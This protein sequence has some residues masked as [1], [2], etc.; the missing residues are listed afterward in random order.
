MKYI[1]RISSIIPILV[2]NIWLLKFTAEYDG[3][4]YFLF[5]L[6]LAILVS[7]ISWILGGQYDKA[8]YYYHELQK[9]KENLQQIFDSVEVTIW[10]NNIVEQR[11]HV[12]KGVEKVSGYPV[13]RFFDDYSFWMKIFLPED[14]QKLDQFYKQVLSGKSDDVEARFIHANGETHWAYV[15]GTP[16]FDKENKVIKING[17]VVDITSRI[18]TVGKLKESENRYRSVVE[19]SPNLIV[20]YQDERLVYANPATTKLLGLEL[21]ELKG[22]SAF[23][24]IHPTF[25]E[26]AVECSKRKSLHNKETD[27]I[28]YKIIKPNGEIAFLELAGNEIAYNGQSAILMV[29]TDVTAKKQQQERIEYMAFHDALTGL[30]NRY[31]YNDTLEEAL[32]RCKQAHHVLGVMF[33]DVDHFKSVNDTMG[34]EAGDELLK[35]VSERIRENVREEDMVARPGGDEFT[36]LLEN[37]HENLVRDIAHRIIKA[38]TSPFLINN[39]EIYASNSIGV[40]LYPVDGDDKETLN[41]KADIAMYFAKKSG[42]NKYQFFNEHG[43]KLARKL[44]LEQDFRSAIEENEFYLEYQPCVELKTGS[45]YC[46]EALVRWKHPI[47]GIIPPNEFIPIMEET[48][49]IVNLGTWVLNEAC[50]QNKEWQKL[51]INVKVAVNVS[52]IQ[53]EAENFVDVV[54]EALLKHEMQSDFLEIE[55]TESVMQNVE[56]S[57]RIIHE[58]KELGVKIS[59]D[60]FG[61]GYSSLSLLSSL[62]IDH[63]KIDKSFIDGITSNS[64]IA[65]VVKKMI[66]MGESLNFDLIAEGIELE[67]QANFLIENGCRYGQGYYFSRPVSPEEIQKLLMQMW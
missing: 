65:S 34:H 28:E 30:P 46:V 6:L 44:Q 54:K 21:S 33:I 5:S 43:D 38:F 7:V 64:N 10:S 53:F 57:T 23:Q 31:M 42:K 51:G 40:S 62:S 27:Y 2:I 45:V 66:E 55:I 35:Q 52:S 56:K 41:S 24:F 58:L 48:G 18:D 60:D 59:I 12:S 32:E 15:S 67:E 8:K 20:I 3:V 11:I 19:L 63:V 61:T 36:V 49:W 26:K 13:K 16:I 39:K 4:A 9:E 29:G 50:R 37:V 47:L 17:I 1:G 25:L 14:R 22:K